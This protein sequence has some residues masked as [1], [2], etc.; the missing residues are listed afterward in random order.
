M[1]RFRRLRKGKEGGAIYP[2]CQAQDQAPTAASAAFVAPDVAA[3]IARWL[4]HLGAERRMS[5][6]TVEAYRR[7]VRS[8]SPSWPSI[9][10]A[11]SR[12]TQLAGS[13]RGRARLH[14]GAA[15]RRHRQPLADARARRRALVR[16]FSRAQRQGQGRRARRRARAEGRQDAAEAAR[17]RGRQAHHRCRPARRRGA[18]A[19]GAGA[20]RRRAGAALRLGP[21]HFRGARPQRA[22]D[23]R[24]GRRHH[25]HRQGQQAAHGAGAAA[26]RSN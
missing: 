5:P 19:M 13:R 11:R 17:D 14:G 10:A 24:Q 15:R 3:E 6:K 1:R 16:A 20:R 4:A 18:R 26:G 2:P 25:R 21:A 7:D 8:S 22:C 9:S 23:A 12:S